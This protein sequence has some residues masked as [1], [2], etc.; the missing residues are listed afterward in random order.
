MVKPALRK[1]VAGDL[2]ERY[3][4]SQRR[5]CRVLRMPRRTLQYRPKSDPEVAALRIAINDA[6]AK[7][8][9]FGWRRILVLLRREGQ[10]VGE[11]RLRRIYREEGLSLRA[12]T[13]KRR[14]SVVVR[15]PRTGATKPNEI[16]SMDFMHDRLTDGRKIRLLMIV[17]IFTRECVALH[18]APAFKAADVV[19]VLRRVTSKRGMPQQIR[20]DNGTEFTAEAFDQWAYWNRVTIDFSR[21]GKPTDNAFIES[22][23]G[24]V[25]QELPNPSWFATLEE[26]RLAAVAWRREYNQVRPHR[27]LGHR[28]PQEYALARERELQS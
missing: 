10:Q 26:V 27:S 13:P 25:R 17:D 15:Q 3:R 23:N 24:K 5:A 12:K 22:F 16:W 2:Q 20:W 18:V 28:T 11:Y 21:P 14:R 4:I 9:R 19:E 8:P 6:A 7:R 1:K